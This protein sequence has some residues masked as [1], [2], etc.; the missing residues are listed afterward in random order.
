MS[1]ENKLP[2]ELCNVVYQYSKD[3]DSDKYSETGLIFKKFMKSIISD[4]NQ[5]NDVNLENDEPETIRDIFFE[6][7]IIEDKT[8]MKDFDA[9]TSYVRQSSVDFQLMY[10]VVYNYNYHNRNESRKL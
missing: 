7:F 9:V 8:S 3:R 2:I 10:F 5:T 1:L 4:F 6:L